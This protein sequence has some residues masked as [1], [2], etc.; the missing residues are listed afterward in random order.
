MD[1]LYRTM[2]FAIA[3]MGILSGGYI[4]QR[5]YQ[6]RR[7]RV[8]ALNLS[9]LGFINLY[10]AF[11]Y[12]SFYITDPSRMDVSSSPLSTY[13]R[14]LNLLYMIVPALIVRRANL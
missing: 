14:P 10:T 2:I 13:L 6:N 7:D 4:L 8:Q 11:V 3:L 12:I 9:V 5:A 1:T